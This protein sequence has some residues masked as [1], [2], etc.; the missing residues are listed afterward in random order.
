MNDPP[1]SN[2]REVEQEGRQLNRKRKHNAGMEGL[3]SLLRVCYSGA[4]HA[5][6][7]ARSARLAALRELAREGELPHLQ[8]HMHL[9]QLQPALPAA[10]LLRESFQGP[11]AATGRAVEGLCCPVL[12]ARPSVRLLPRGAARLPLA[13]YILPPHSRVSCEP[14]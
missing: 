4:P 6:G 13:P 9:Q 5:R 7:P 12:A 14:F 3:G 11:T 2:H 8:A 10:P 1:V